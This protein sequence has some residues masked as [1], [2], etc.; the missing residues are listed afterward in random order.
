M[1]VG[2]GTTRTAAPAR[3]CSAVK[4]CRPAARQRCRR[5][6]RER[7]GQQRQAG[8]HGDRQHHGG[9]LTS[10]RRADARPEPRP[11][12]QPA[13]D[14]VDPHGEQ[15]R[16]RAVGQDR[17]PVRQDRRQQLVLLEPVPGQA[18]RGIGDSARL[19]MAAEREDHQ[20]RQRERRRQARGPAPADD[21]RER[22]HD[23]QRPAEV[24]Q[25]LGQPAVVGRRRRRAARGME[26]QVRRRRHEP[27]RLV[28]VVIRRIERAVLDERSAEL[29]PQRRPGQRERDGA[30]D[31]EPGR[32]GQDPPYRRGRPGGGQGDHRE[33]PG[34]GG[35]QGDF[36]ADEQL[37]GDQQA[38]PGTGPHRRGHPASPATASPATARPATASPVGCLPDR[39]VQR[40]GRQPDAGVDDQRRQ[41]AQ[42]QVV[43]ADR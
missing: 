16:G 43:V 27:R 4:V 34:Q 22:E 37:R 39:R 31:D 38:E 25:V 19:R 32:R 23:D 28:H 33:H 9:H 21:R 17:Q 18:H 36:L 11:G 3:R 7:P 30:A 35:D 42:Q 8:E 1:L 20:H 5:P 15:D 6:G 24:G 40:A 14:L 10:A 13:G 41:E 29:S 26:E 12:G 2:T